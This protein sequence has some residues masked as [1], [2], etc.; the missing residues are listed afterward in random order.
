[1]SASVSVDRPNILLIALDQW[2]GDCLSALGHPVVQ[3]PNFD[4][5]A[6]EG[7]LFKRHYSVAAPCGPARASLFTGLYVHNHRSVRNRVPLDARFT[8]IALEARKFGYSPKLFGF[9]DTTLDPRTLAPGDPGLTTS[10]SILPG[11]EAGLDMPGDGGPWLEWL[12][13]RGY[14]IPRSPRDIWRPG[15]PR[16]AVDAQPTVFRAEESETAYLTNAAIEFFDE[17]EDRPWFAHLSYFRP[18]HPYI[19]PEP[20]NRLYRPQDAPLPVRAAQ[21]ETEADGH[22][23]VQAL[24][25]VSW[26]GVFLFKTSCRWPRST[27]TALASSALYIMDRSVNATRR[28]DGSP[29][30]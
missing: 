21:P 20:F 29:H 16:A 8:N 6:R 25:G 30:I 28:S 22:A 17:Q 14:S 19:A 7:V 27:R 18:H 11:F 10:A 1:M 15:E 26:Q 12:G 5:L 23:F 9:T 4:A 24:A 13:E 2:R 3:T